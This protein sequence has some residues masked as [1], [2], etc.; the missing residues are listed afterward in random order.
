MELSLMTKL[1]RLLSLL[2]LLVISGC[3]GLQP[4]NHTARAGD[5]IAIAAGWKH[6][7]SRDQLTVT[8][9]PSIGSDIVYLPGDDAVRASINF[10]PDPTSY[11]AVG[12]E[13]TMK[14]TYNNGRNYGGAVSSGFTNSDPDWWQTTVFVD[15]PSTLPVGQ[16]YVQLTSSG[17]FGESWGVPVEIVGGIGSP[18]TLPAEINGSISNIQLR[19]LERSPNYEIQFSGAITPH[20][21]QVNLT[22]DPDEYDAN[23]YA[24]KNAYVVNPRGDVKSV[25]WK[26]DGQNMRVLLSFTHESPMH[27]DIS[28]FKFYVAGGTTGLQIQS[29]DAFDINGDPVTGVIANVVNH[30]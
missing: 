15:L 18:H 27:T 23:G 13:E 26:D 29:V 16:T 3:A 21:I 9:T 11:M 8:F 17:S 22:H 25:N 14:G 19:T 2:S 1:F 12:Y 24:T 28:R 10:Y 30:F 6:Q 5:T 20:A 7:F 4:F